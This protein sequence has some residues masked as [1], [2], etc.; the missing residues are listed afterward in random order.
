MK[1]INLILLIL[2]STLVVSLITILV[3]DYSK[4][5]QV[6][7][8]GVT[9]T[10]TDENIVGMNADPGFYYGRLQRGM[11]G[12]KYLTINNGDE[13][14]IVNV[15]KKGEI[16]DWMSNLNNFLMTA[17]ESRNISFSVMIPLD[18]ESRLYEG[19]IMIV[20]RKA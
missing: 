11:G 19:E 17:G 10:V 20:L 13:A 6:Q 7:K 5:K 9:V 12:T 16:S 3:F 4:I 14:V 18:A 15:V 2:I 8:Y 1:K